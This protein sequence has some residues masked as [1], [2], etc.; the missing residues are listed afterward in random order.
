MKTKKIKQ[1]RHEFKNY[2]I[3]NYKNV[4]EIT[5][6][7]YLCDSFYVYRRQSEFSVNFFDLFKSKDDIANFEKELLI[8]QTARK[9]IKNPKGSTQAYLKGLYR[10]YNFFEEEY[11]R[12]DNFI[13]LKTIQ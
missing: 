1:L 11:G 7:T 8:Q 4:S 13:K 5:I 9:N 10:L 2:L 12:I 6:K 3:K